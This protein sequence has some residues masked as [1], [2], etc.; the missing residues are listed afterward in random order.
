MKAKALKLKLKV[1]A[2]MGVGVEAQTDARGTIALADISA[3]LVNNQESSRLFK[4]IVSVH[5]QADARG[6]NGHMY[7]VTAEVKLGC[8]DL[9]RACR[10]RRSA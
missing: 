4:Q 3:Q 8:A 6:W 1:K 7:T 5:L 10:L 2:E 9:M